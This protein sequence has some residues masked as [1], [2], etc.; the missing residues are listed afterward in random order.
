MPTESS[1]KRYKC[2]HLKVCPSSWSNW[3]TTGVYVMHYMNITILEQYTYHVYPSDMTFAY[4][5]EETTIL[6]STCLQ[7][8]KGTAGNALDAGKERSHD[9]ALACTEAGAEHQNRA[10]HRHANT[11][12]ERAKVI[13]AYLPVGSSSWRGW[14]LLWWTIGSMNTAL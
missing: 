7:Y 2:V 12:V 6:V 5:E 13:S 4:A 10:H 9:I 14:L 11:N 3:S 1:A 8:C